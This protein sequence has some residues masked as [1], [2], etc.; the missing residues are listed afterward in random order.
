MR[1]LLLLLAFLA[2]SLS[3]AAPAPYAKP[4]P[5]RKTTTTT[6]TKKTT[7][8]TTKKTTTTTTTTKKTTTKKTSSTTTTAAT[9]SATS[10]GGLTC[11]VAG[12]DKTSSYNYDGSGTTAN[13]ASCSSKCNADSKCLSFAFGSG[14]CMLYSIAAYVALC[15][16][17]TDYADHS[18]FR[19]RKRSFW[20]PIFVL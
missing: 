3:L 7:T 4:N 12:Y 1:S 5:A 11:G 18:Q 20:Q 17:L 2:I 19:K 13:L 10:S 15:P 14:A 6:T 9:T 16:S 8:T